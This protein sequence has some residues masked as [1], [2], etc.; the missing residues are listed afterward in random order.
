MRLL[1]VRHG[2]A[3]DRHPEGDR[4]RE[5]S[6]QGRE[7]IAALFP[8]VRDKAFSADLVV[9][10]PYVRAR[11]TSDLLAPAV[12]G[13]SSE[14]VRREVSSSVTPDGD[15]REFLAEVQAWAAQGYQAVVVFSHNPFVS[16]LTQWLVQAEWKGEVEFHTPSL[17]ALDF[18]DGLEPHQGRLLW[19]LH[20]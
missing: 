7:R 13:A 11:Q 16:E 19:A 12:V 4:Y 20:P 6:V 18:P 9:S 5:L 1:V 14:T 2:K 8:L 3:V 17:W 10:S 15:P